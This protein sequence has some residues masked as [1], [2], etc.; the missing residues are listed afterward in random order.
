ML[1]PRTAEVPM[2]FAAL[3]EVLLADYYRLQPADATGLGCNE[4]DARG[5]D[6]TDAGHAEWS[7]WLASAEARVLAVDAGSLTRD[8]AIDRRILL[9]NLA[10]MRFAQDELRDHAWNP[11]SYVYLFGGTLFTMLSREYAP[12]PDRLGAVAAR[13]RTLPAALDGAQQALSA[14]GG[15][16][17]SRY[18]AEMT[19]ER[20]P[21]VGDL[22]GLAV[23]EAEGAG[24]RG[25]L[26]EVQSAAEIASAALDAWG[27]WVRIELAP[28]AT[29]A[30]R[31]APELHA[32]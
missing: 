24:D 2:N 30:L 4:H 25:L 8:E 26:E 10:A 14:T 1:L 17:V 20:M 27:A 22:V 12:L 18:H 11:I 19:V 21:G 3:V 5:R 13:L 16:R 7:R 6:L 15:R 29:G 9:D 32:A 31:P 28:A 23:S